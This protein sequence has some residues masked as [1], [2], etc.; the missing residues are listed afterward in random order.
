MSGDRIG[1]ISRIDNA[2]RI[3]VVKAVMGAWRRHDIDELLSHMAPEVVWHYQ[4]G[5]RPVEG[6]DNMRKVLDK[7]QHH[8]RESRWRLVRYAES[9]DAVLIEGVDDFVNP[10]GHRVR[11]PYMGVYEFDGATITAWRDYVDLGL[12]MK[13]GAGEPLDEWLLPLVEAGEELS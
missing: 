7:L 11:A 6:V 5:S 9:D 10:D 13:A 1:D 12:M 3:E 4:V 8:Q 2:S